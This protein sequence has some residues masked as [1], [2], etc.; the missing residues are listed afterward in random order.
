MFDFKLNPALQVKQWLGE[1]YKQVAQLLVQ[2]RQVVEVNKEYFPLGQLVMQFPLLRAKF[3]RQEVQVE[4][5]EQAKQ[6]PG[7]K[8]QNP[9]SG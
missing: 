6:G 3:E 7:Q 9:L 2:A 5:P 4:A 8:L 1:L